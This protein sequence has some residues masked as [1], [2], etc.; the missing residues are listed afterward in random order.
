MG[1]RIDLDPVAEG[2]DRALEHPW[3]QLA[4]RLFPRA[5]AE[6]RAARDRL[7]ELAGQAQARVEAHVAQ[8]LEGLED[9]AIATAKRAWGR[10]V[11]NRRKPRKRKALKR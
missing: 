3:G 10:L 6:V 9:E 2:I 4:Q 8:E 5:A 11:G 1:V 7:P